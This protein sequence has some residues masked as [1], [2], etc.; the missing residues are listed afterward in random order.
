MIKLL[1][2]MFIPDFK[3][4]E[5]SVVREKYSVL[6]GVLGI[7]CNV[8]LFAIKIIIGFL[9]NSIAVISDAFNNLADIGTSLVSIVS[10]KLSNKHPDKDHP[11]GHGRVEYIA[12][13][14]V[15]FLIMLV[16]FELLKTSFDKIINPVAMK[17]D[18]IMTVFL[19]LS[20]LIKV[21][22]FS[23]NS[24]MG[25]T[26]KSSILKATAQ[27]SLSDCIST[28]AV[29]VSII[30]AHFFPSIPFDGIIGMIVSVIIMYAGFN[31]AKEVINVLLGAPPEPEFIQKITDILMAN[32]EIIGVHDL[33]VHDYGPGRV[34]ASVHAEVSDKCD[35]VKAHEA[36]DATEVRAEAELGIILV[37][38]MD[39]VTTDNEF[40]NGLKAMAEGIVKEYNS[41]Y[42][43]HDFRITD[44]ENRI[45]MIF[46]MTV[47]FGTDEKAR[48]AVADAVATKIH[49][50]DE[51]YYAVIKVEGAY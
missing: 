19:A 24:Y 42:T 32:D 4:T 41:E 29:I 36:I 20:V 11:F 44:G 26:I 23:Y 49:E 1:I 9:I 3:N 22:M 25:K 2:K 5:N 40:V 43:I 37:I 45:N 34:I 21:W 12:S 30:L 16:G 51:K 33:I 6:S 38:H 7:F 35:I 17:F 15:S 39:P 8:L 14:I 31:I 28:A 48:K 10:V 47:P 46:D 27:D 50:T 18:V 13:L